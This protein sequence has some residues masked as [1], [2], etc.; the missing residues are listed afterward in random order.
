MTRVEAAE[1]L[2]AN[3]G[4]LRSQELVD[5]VASDSTCDVVACPGGGK[6]TAL[7]VKVALEL[8][9]WKDRSRGILALSHT[10]VARRE[11]ENRASLTSGSAAILRPPHFLGTIQSFVD[12][13]L[14]FPYM[15]GLD[16]TP[17]IID[18]DVAAAS[19]QRILTGAQYRGAV[20]WGMRGRSRDLTRLEIGAEPDTI[21]IGGEG[22]GI[23]VGTPTYR[24]LLDA[25]ERSIRTGVFR[26][27]DMYAY[28][29]RNL[30]ANPWVIGILRNRFP[31]VLIDEMQ[32]TDASQSRLL[33]LIFPRNVAR[34]HT[35]GDPDQSIYGISEEVHEAG[36]FPVEPILHLRESR[37]FGSFIAGAVSSISANGQLILGAPEGEVA[38]HTILLYT[39]ETVQ[40]VLDAFAR[41]VASM[42]EPGSLVQAHAVGMRKSQPA[43]AG[44]ELRANLATYLPTYQSSAYQS[45]PEALI[46]HAFEARRRAPSQ[47]REST[48]IMNRA[49]DDLFQRWNSEIGRE[50]FRTMKRS[51]EPRAAFGDIILDLVLARA[52]DER[53]WEHITGALRAECTRLLGAPAQD[54][55]HYLRFIN[56]QC[57]EEQHRR[58]TKVVECDRDIVVE[59]RVDTIHGVKGETHTATLVLETYKHTHDLRA[60][61]PLL[62]GRRR[63]TGNENQ[64]LKQ[65]LKTIFVGMSRPQNLVC[66]ALQEAG[67]AERDAGLLEAQGWTI[68]RL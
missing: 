7:A 45:A 15:R 10:N 49:F 24:S 11:I 51:L 44:N 31:V 48:Q 55:D 68:V 65:R 41:I 13:F 50:Q 26:Y 40:L 5:V 21:T 57:L 47:F 42:A 62:S 2:I 39:G 14:A 23:G 37:R 43:P 56:L 59:I 67:L 9:S 36:G 18:D 25:K 61:M 27:H 17:R 16:L 63:V 12:H 60:L 64:S 6:T 8:E 66:L 58:N 32:D 4:L 28:A 38:P 33:D 19:L 20:A 53:T 54:Q 3:L 22:L 29:E 52:I 1:R 35:F 46:A 30:R 34:V